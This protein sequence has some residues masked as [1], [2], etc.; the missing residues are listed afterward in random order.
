MLENKLDSA[1]IEWLHK[2]MDNPKD[3]GKLTTR[4]LQEISL[5]IFPEEVHRYIFP[6]QDD[7]HCSVQ[8]RKLYKE[9]FY[10]SLNLM[11]YENL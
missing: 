8:Q 1:T 10:I 3:Y 11:R 9:R 4:R 2:V 7:C 5:K 6:N